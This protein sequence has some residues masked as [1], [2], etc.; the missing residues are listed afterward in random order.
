[1]L[2]NYPPGATPQQY[3]EWACLHHDTSVEI[4]EPTCRIC[5][6]ESDGLCAECQIQDAPYLE[7]AHA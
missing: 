2:S 5:G 4:Q 1:M 3:E 7:E 6:V